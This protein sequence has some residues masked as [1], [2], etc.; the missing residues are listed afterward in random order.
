MSSGTTSVIDRY[1][2]GAPLLLYAISGLTREHEL[3]RPGPGEWSIAELVGHLLDSDLV[4]GDRMK[5]VI[6]EEDPILY[7]YDENAWINRLNSQSLPVEEAAH[8]F[9]ANRRWMTRILRQC[10]DSDF[11]RS[12]NH[13]ETG[14]KTLAD[15]VAGAIGHLDHHLRFHYTKRANLGIAIPPRYTAQ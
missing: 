11:A 15:L 10:S 2:E 6:A 14:R 9:A 5:R 7:A 1:A 3:A 12:G 8:L 4:Y 13:T